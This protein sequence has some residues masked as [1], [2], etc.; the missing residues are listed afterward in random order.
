MVVSAYMKLDKDGLWYSGAL[1]GVDQ[2]Q[3]K[4]HNGPW[5]V[6]RDLG[7]GKY[8]RRVDE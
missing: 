5:L 2:I 7:D 3:V 1:M 4:F 8:E 6:L